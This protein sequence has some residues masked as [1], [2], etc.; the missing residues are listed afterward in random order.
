MK[1]VDS[2]AREIARSARLAAVL[3][4]PV[5]MAG[6]LLIELLGGLEG[7]GKL[8]FLALVAPI[9]LL[10]PLTGS[11]GELASW[12]VVVVAEFAYLTLVVV[13]VRALGRLVREHV[14]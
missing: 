3:F 4:V 11:E 1:P 10:E 8:L 9:L 5:A 2:C 6:G 13:V 7:G 14:R 12:C